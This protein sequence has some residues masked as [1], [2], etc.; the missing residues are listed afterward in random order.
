MV[1][2]LSFSHSRQWLQ[3]LKKDFAPLV[4]AF[5]VS[6]G[7]VSMICHNLVLGFRAGLQVAGFLAI[8]LL[9]VSELFRVRSR[10]DALALGM[11]IGAVIFV[12]CGQ[13]ATLL[14]LPTLTLWILPA[15]AFTVLA[16]RKPLFCDTSNWTWPDL[17][18]LLPIS[19]A[20]FSIQTFSRLNQI[21]LDPRAIDG[22]LSVHNSLSVSLVEVGPAQWLAG[23]DLSV[24]YHWLSNA[25]AGELQRW[26]ESDPFIQL[27]ILLPIVSMLATILAASAIGERLG[28]SPFARGIGCLFLVGG[29]A[30]GSGILPLHETSVSPYSPSLLIGIPAFLCL[31]LSLL[32]YSDQRT[33]PHQAALIGITSFAV[34]MSRINLILFIPLIILGVF[35]CCRPLKKSK[36]LFAAIA[37]VSGIIIAIGLLFA[38]RST[39]GVAGAWIFEP[40]FDLLQFLGLV[41]IFNQLGLA[42]AV[43]SLLGLVGVSLLGLVHVWVRGDQRWVA[44]CSVIVLAGLL[45]VSLTRQAG[46]SHFSFIIFAMCPA[47]LVAGLGAGSALEELWSASRRRTMVALIM[48][49]LIIAAEIVAQDAVKSRIAEQ[50]YQ[51]LI[52]WGIP[53]LGL[54]LAGCLSLLICLWFR[55]TTAQFTLACSLGLVSTVIVLATWGY[56]DGSLRTEPTA[57]STVNVQNGLASTDL[58]AGS[59]VANN[60]DQDGVFATNRQCALIDAVPPAC[61]SNRFDISGLGKRQA[62][63]EGAS[64][65]VSTDFSRE[66]T[67]LQVYE[68]RISLSAQFALAPSIAIAAKLRDMGVGYYWLDKTL[69]FSPDIS[70]VSSLIFENSRVSILQL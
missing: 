3:Q 12:L 70:K 21:G 27:T 59:W 24:R 56:R 19:M 66:G 25:L 36:L 6:C 63:I 48:T 28:F 32:I 30:L 54:L 62:L 9:A 18:A 14:D 60:T 37:G 22:D 38:P 34:V 1:S 31:W 35:F 17:W 41:P 5:L 8:G 15:T 40:N 51:G 16:F 11:L 64:N 55:P 47:L 65:S 2:T 10:R 68:D 53:L 49:M 26:T 29:T 61:V 43:S 44:V 7:L 50:A 33:R 52:R 57:G 4:L 42:L 69:P 58:E 13:V 46:Y 39:G 67:Q 20:A 45:G 23:L